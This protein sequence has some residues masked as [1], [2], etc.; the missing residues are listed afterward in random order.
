MNPSVFYASLHFI[1]LALGFTGLFVRGLELRSLNRGEKKDL[2]RLFLADNLWGVAALLWIGSGV[3]RAFGGMEKGTEYY[4]ANH[5]FAAKLG[6][7]AIV[8]LLEI[9][10]MITFVRL[11]IKGAKH[12]GATDLKRFKKFQVMNDI[13]V[14]LVLLIPV[15]ASLMARGHE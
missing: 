15:F 9:W 2:N 3:M 4:L 1:A 10:P 5:W 12:A 7:F 13:Q 6:L 8:F 11:R 14:V